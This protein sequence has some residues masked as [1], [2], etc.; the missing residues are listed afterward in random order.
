MT[1]DGDPTQGARERS[2]AF[3]V[4]R[5]LVLHRKPSGPFEGQA[6]PKDLDGG[7]TSSPGVTRTGASAS[8][9]PFCPHLGAD[10][11]TELREAGY[12]VA[13]SSVPSM[14]MSTMQAA[15][16]WPR[17]LPTRPRP[18][19][20]ESSRPRRFLAWSFA[21]WGIEGQAPQWSLPADSQ[22]EAGWS[23]FEIK[24]I[25]F[26]GHPQETTEN[27]VD[28]GHLR[29]VHGYGNVDRPG[30]NV[31][32][33]ALSGEPLRLPA[34]PDDRQDCNDDLRPLRRHPYLWAGRRD[35][36]GSSC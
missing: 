34:H 17:P 6:H 31:G 25:R 4:S 10:L 20:C 27:S 16:V 5:G 29:Y 7:R 24:T 35:E 14:A 13:G 21:W 30:A 36:S 23:D 11:G 26:P 2:T 22:E 9:R 18:R 19:S 3:P 28:L 15:S 12:A 33:R 1:R 32:G 8:P